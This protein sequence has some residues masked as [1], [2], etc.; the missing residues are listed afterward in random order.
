MAIRTLSIVFPAM[1][2]IG[3]FSHTLDL[4]GE[5]F[6]TPILEE[7]VK[8]WIN[9]FFR[10]P[11]T[12]LAWSTRTGLPAPT[13]SAT[14]W[15][16]MM[17]HLHDSFGDVKSFLDDDSLPPSRLKLLEI[18]NDAPRNRKLQIELAVTVDAGEQ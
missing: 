8:V 13:Y 11:K 9:M 10:S 4:V 14:R 16:E 6:N 18:L 2:D 7:F 1:V 3:Y 5:T 12:K 17:K 15:W